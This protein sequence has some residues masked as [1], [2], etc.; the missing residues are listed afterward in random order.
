MIP[1][2]NKKKKKKVRGH[3]SQNNSSQIYSSLYYASQ[4]INCQ[5]S[6]VISQKLSKKK[7]FWE[8]EE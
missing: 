6:H 4:T 7:Q 5:F 3:I 1:P 8:T 2:S